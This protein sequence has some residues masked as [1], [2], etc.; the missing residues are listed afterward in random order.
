MVGDIATEGFGRGLG[1]GFM[2]VANFL[3]LISIALCIMNLLPIP[4]LDGGLILL[5]IFELL[6]RRPL[7][8]KAIYVFQLVGTTLIF[9]LLLFSVFG[10]ILFLFGVH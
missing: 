10:D 8:P 2:A 1:A 5:F 7:H 6:T 3:A 9:G 4:A